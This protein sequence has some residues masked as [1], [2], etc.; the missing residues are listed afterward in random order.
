MLAYPSGLMW[1]RKPE[2]LDKTTDFGLATTILP[3]GA[4]WLSGKVS[5][6]GARGRGFET[7]LLFV[8]SFSK[9]LYSLKVLV[10]VGPEPPLPGY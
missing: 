7:Y 9:T 2:N 1:C 6:S 10:H 4:Q 5:D 3:Q 8:V